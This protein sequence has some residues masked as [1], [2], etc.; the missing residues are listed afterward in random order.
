MDRI[1]LE[2]I[3][4]TDILVVGGGMAGVC[5][6][7]Q[8]ARL[9]SKVTLVEEELFLGGCSS[10]SFRLR[11]DGAGGM[12]HEYGR[13]T[14]IVEEL[15]SEGAYYRANMEP[16]ISN[17]PNSK[18]GVPM[19]G[20]KNDIWSLVVL[21]QKCEEAGVRLLLKTVVFGVVKEENRIKLVQA[22][23]LKNNKII[24]IKIN[25]IVID[26]S[27]DG[28][29]A[30]KAG[31][32][33]SIG[34]E[35]RDEYNESYAPLKSNK[36][37]MG[38][39]LMFIMIDKGR[40]VEFIPPPGTPVYKEDVDLPLKVR[41]VNAD[42]KHAGFS[43][44]SAFT[45]ECQL[46]IVWTA[47]Y[48]GHLNILEDREEVYNGLIKMVFGIVDHI[49][50]QQDHGADNYE[51]LW[52]SPKIGRRE[53]RRFKGDYILTQNDIMN[54]VSF[55]DA[56]AYGGRVIDVH[57]PDE[58]GKFTMVTF[59][60]LPPLYSIPYR[61]LYSKDVDNLMLAGRL[62]SGTRIALGSYR[63][64]KT[65]ATTGQA[66]GVAAHLA[67]KYGINSR[68][69][70]QKH[71]FELQQTLLREDATILGV[72]NQDR[73]D[74]AR[75]SKVSATSETKGGEAS[76]VTNGVNRQYSSDKT[77]MW[78]S[79]PN[80]SLPQILHLDFQE[81]KRISCIQ[82]T[83]DTAL[84]RARESDVNIRVFKK[85]V[86]DYKIQSFNNNSTWVDIVSVKGNYQR[87]RVHKFDGILTNQIRIVIESNN[88]EPGGVTSNS[89]R[90][91]EVRVYE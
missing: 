38:D 31:A 47:E 22:L 3:V 39:G 35:A 12:N 41:V 82:L 54:A 56:V 52:I 17:D 91:C 6:A 1:K 90:V 2:K 14:G 72:K 48:G 30:C 29:V 55:E 77:N 23:D 69:V 44:H 60:E 45:S 51:L 89:A 9:G 25:N 63:V 79:S 16:S 43:G 65:L 5:A 19:Y 74:I 20:F 75:T 71:I 64:Q 80:C 73:S 86:K 50:N 21:K 62:I 59:Y 68:E 67:S 87:H 26:A 70:G 57:Q 85:T 4:E 36:R 76:N 78:I 84:N 15:E 81:K 10:P 53:G 61:C 66:V 7:I 42:K 37:T 28:V 34:Q 88:E 83:F 40:P 13:E 8:S 46:C 49:K 11:V 32:E 24:G 58:N 27:G 33:Y 18:D